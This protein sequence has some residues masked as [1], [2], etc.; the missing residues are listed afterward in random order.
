LKKDVFRT[1]F[2]VPLLNSYIM[3]IQSIFAWLFN[4]LKRQHY[5][6]QKNKI[7][8]YRVWTCHLLRGGEKSQYLDTSCFI[9]EIKDLVDIYTTWVVISDQS[10]QFLWTSDQW[11]QIFNKQWVVRTKF[12]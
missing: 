10:G 2:R 4:I 6:L 5:Y 11:E 3:V 12:Q 9:C 7:A 8:S 1:Y